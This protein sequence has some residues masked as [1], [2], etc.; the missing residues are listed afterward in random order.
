[1][2][3]CRILV[4]LPRGVCVSPLCARTKILTFWQQLERTSRL[5]SSGYA[6]YVR[7]PV[8][9]CVSVVVCACDDEPLSSLFRQI[10]D[11]YRLLLS[12]LD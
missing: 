8:C 5:D 4:V 7:I 6:M 12:S 1:M 9:Q 11:S 3:F 2:K 10:P